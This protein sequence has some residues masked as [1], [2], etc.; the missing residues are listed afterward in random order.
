MLERPVV[1]AGRR[2]TGTVNAI[3]VRFARKIPPDAVPA[4]ALPRINISLFGATAQR[5][6]P[7]RKT[8]ITRKNTCFRGKFWYS[9]PQVG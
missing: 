7:I 3:S 9:F 2:C 5:I 4:T 6:D 1:Y 8:V